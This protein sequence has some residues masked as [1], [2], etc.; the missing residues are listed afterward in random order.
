MRNN[1]ITPHS[2]TTEIEPGKAHGDERGENARNR[3]GATLLELLIAIT[4]SSLVFTLSC[5]VFMDIFKG[6]LLQKNRT[7]TVQNMLLK[8]KQIEHGLPAIEAVSECNDHSLKCIRIGADTLS[9]IQFSGDSLCV[10]GKAICRKLSDCTFSLCK[11]TGQ[12]PWVL[13][14]NAHALNGRWFGSAIG[15]RQ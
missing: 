2:S 9:T 6:F 1:K 4:V 14:W 8:K 11:K 12:G 10:D 5:I 3:F 13:L 7:E 15:E